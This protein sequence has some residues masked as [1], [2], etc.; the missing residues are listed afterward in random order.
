MDVTYNS[1][2]YRLPD[3][4]II[5]LGKCGTTTLAE[6]LSAHP[7]VGISSIKEPHFFSY[8]F[9]FERGIPWYATLFNHCR[10]ARIIGEAS[11][12]YSRIHQHSEV[13]DRLLEYLP[14]ARIIMMVRHPM[15]RI[16]SAYMEWLA[17]PNHDQTYSSIN[18]AIVGMSTFIES[19]RYWTIYDAYRTR[20]G[21]DNIHV[22][23]FDDL[24]NK[25][26][27]AFAEVCRFLRVD[28]TWLPAKETIRAN[29]RSEVEQRARNLGRD[30]G[31][32][33]LSWSQKSRDLLR[34]ELET[35]INQFL[36]HFNKEDLW[37]DLF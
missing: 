23:W 10:D 15:E 32:V 37:P 31:V 24:K 25:Q 26:H 27:E 9:I 5:G 22:V 21:E 18:E 2:A 11:T 19:S 30:A 33:D 1:R 16:V 28:D 14:D 12:S 4:L 7:E 29:A 13:P 36:R 20:F 8:E 17:T 35:E 34:R 6:L 3:F